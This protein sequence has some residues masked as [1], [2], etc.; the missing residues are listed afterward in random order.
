M[1]S[2]NPILPSARGRALWWLGRILSWLETPADDPFRPRELPL[3]LWR[4]RRYVC[5]A[6]ERF[7]ESA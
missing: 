2:A 3:G 7:E 6:L 1:A 4:L 5:R